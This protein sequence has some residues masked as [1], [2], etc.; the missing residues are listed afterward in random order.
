MLKEL[1]RNSSVQKIKDY[2]SFCE[3]LQLR[4]KNVLQAITTPVCNSSRAA[5]VLSNNACTA[6][7]NGVNS[8]DKPGPNTIPK[9]KA[10]A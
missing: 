8:I 2:F 4:I 7:T 9:K 10:Q 1:K 6:M 3:T 5:P